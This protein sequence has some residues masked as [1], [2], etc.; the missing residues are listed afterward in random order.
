[1][2]EQ[3]ATV[4]LMGHATTAGRIVMEN[5]LL[6][7]DVPEGDTFRTE[8]YGMGAIYSVKIV[9]EEISRAFVKPVVCAYEYDAPI[10]TREQHEKRVRELERKISGMMFEND[11]LKRRLTTVNGLPAPLDDGLGA[12]GEEIPFDD[13]EDYEDDE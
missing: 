6:R 13:G 8:Y 9:S 12:N 10:V 1:M 4:E 11:E 2:S 3:W 5:G 7:V